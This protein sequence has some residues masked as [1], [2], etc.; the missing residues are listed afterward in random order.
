[1]I[2]IN[3][4]KILDQIVFAPQILPTLIHKAHDAQQILELNPNQNTAFI[5]IDLI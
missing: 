5:L 2:D 4:I 1:M 3:N